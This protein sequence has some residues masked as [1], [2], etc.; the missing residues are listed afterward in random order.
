[1]LR[2]VVNWAARIGVAVAVMAL[3]AQVSNQPTGETPERGMLRL[4]WRSLGERV[5]VCRELSAE[6]LAGVPAHMRQAEECTTYIL[7]YRLR[8]MVDGEALISRVVR[9]AGAKSDR[10][11]YVQEDITLPPGEHTLAVSFTVAGPPADL[12]DG[13]LGEAEREA[14]EQ[15]RSRARAYRLQRRFRAEPGEVALLVLREGAGD[16]EGAGFELRRSSRSRPRT[17]A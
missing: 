16:G 6:E 1:M 12:A 13:G 11:L 9:P 3:L 15:A 2:R 5:R 4:A 7:P 14:L 8:V 10:P 17:P